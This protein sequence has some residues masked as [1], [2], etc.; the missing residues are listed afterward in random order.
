MRRCRPPIACSS[1]I[2]CQRELRTLE[3]VKGSTSRVNLMPDLPLEHAADNAEVRRLLD[4]VMPMAI[5][6][7]AKYHYLHESPSARP[8]A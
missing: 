5:P 3:H 1:S 4:A 8:G 2:E 7:F 6:Q